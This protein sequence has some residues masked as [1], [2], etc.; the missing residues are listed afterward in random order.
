M[1]HPRHAQSD[2]SAGRTSARCLIRPTFRGDRILRGIPAGA[3]AISANVTVTNA[4]ADGRLVVYPGDLPVPPQVETVVFRA[5][6]TRANNTILAFARDGS[7]S[8]NAENATSG[9]LD[10]IVDVTGYFE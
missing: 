10:L 8:F 5:G 7:G 6:R 4:T 2:Q 3:Q 9:S 1:S